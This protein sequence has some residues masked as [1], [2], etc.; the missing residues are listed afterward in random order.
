MKAIHGKIAIAS[1]ALAPTFVAM[2]VAPV[3]AATVEIADGDVSSPITVADVSRHGD[4]IVGTL[5]NQGTDEVR[6]IRLL[7]DVAFLWKDELHPGEDSPGRSAVLTVAGPIAPR[8]RLAFEFTP[9][10]PLPERNDGRYAE[11]K[12]RVMGYNSVTAAH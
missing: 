12:V 3:A 7:I 5:V 4:Q 2:P 10:P 9:S 11:P 8:G 1:L 6:N